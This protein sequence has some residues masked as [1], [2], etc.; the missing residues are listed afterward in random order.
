MTS[1]GLFFVPQVAVFSR[2]WRTAR[3]EGHIKLSRPL[4]ETGRRSLITVETFISLKPSLY[5]LV[6]E[7]CDAAIEKLKASFVSVFG[8]LLW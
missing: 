2:T 3:Q 1:S 5:S 8:S 4:M 6:V 7:V